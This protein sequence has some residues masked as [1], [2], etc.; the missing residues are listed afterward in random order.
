MR[1]YEEWRAELGEVDRLL[2]LSDGD[3][4]V[5]PDAIASDASDFV[6]SSLNVEFAP[7]E[8]EKHATIAI[9]DDTLYEPVESLV[10]EIFG[11][12][13]PQVAPIFGLQSD[14][15]GTVFGRA[16]V[17]I[18]D[19]DSPPRFGLG[20]IAGGGGSCETFESAR[21]ARHCVGDIIC[22][23]REGEAFQLSVRWTGGNPLGRA[24]VRYELS[25]GSAEF[26]NDDRE[27]DYTPGGEGSVPFIDGNPENGSV[28]K[29]MLRA[30][31]DARVEGLEH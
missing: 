14:N 8:V 28:A 2:E 21:H 27:T 7:G 22:M 13:N 9:V 31:R 15:E 30:S 20:S 19:D 11:L 26:V 5:T 17:R 18:Q 3:L 29:V 23:L 1:A 16:E 6:P 10:V 24:L 4:A 25:D 12:S